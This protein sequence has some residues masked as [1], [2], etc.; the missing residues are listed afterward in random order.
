MIW[1]IGL[2]IQIYSG[3]ADD[4]DDD[5]DDDNDEDDQS[6]CHLTFCMG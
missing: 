2:F 5:D 1:W 3:A 6:S 4:D